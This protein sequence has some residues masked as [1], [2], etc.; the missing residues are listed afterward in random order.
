MIKENKYLEKLLNKVE[1]ENE[2][3]K[4]EMKLVY[5]TAKNFLE[6]QLKCRRKNG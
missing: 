2:K 3:T 4:E 1:F 6:K 5:K